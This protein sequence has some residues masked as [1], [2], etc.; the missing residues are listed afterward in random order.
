MTG[1]MYTY[2]YI[3]YRVTR[4]LINLDAI[5]SRDKEKCDNARE[6]AL[7]IFISLPFLLFFLSRR[8]SMNYAD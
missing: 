1:I 6:L 2:I 4:A 5:I 7:I 8:A 3:R